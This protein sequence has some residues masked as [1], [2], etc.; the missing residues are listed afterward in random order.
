MFTSWLTARAGRLAAV[1]QQFDILFARMQELAG[2]HL[3]TFAGRAYADRMFEG[4]GFCAQ[5]LK[6]TGDPAEALMIP[7]WGS[8]ERDTQSCES[9]WSA[10]DGS[11]RPYN[12]A[13]ENYPYALRQR[14]VRS[15][16][17]A[18][19]V[20]NQKVAS[21]SGR[22]NEK[23]SAAVFSE[24]TGA[25]HPSA[26]GHAAMADALMLTLRPLLYRMLYEE[27]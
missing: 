22:I 20:V 21:R 6:R 10:R 4:H 17:D 24:T 19:M 27:P 11:W 14:W 25:L 16:N 8:A 26:E 23:A 7:C 13:T 18:Y 3:W 2:D 5:N 15:F 9:N 12:P 1:R